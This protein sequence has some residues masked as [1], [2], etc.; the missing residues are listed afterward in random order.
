MQTVVFYVFDVVCL[1]VCNIEIRGKNQRYLRVSDRSLA[2]MSK[3]RRRSEASEVETDEYPA[4][5]R[6]TGDKWT[7]PPAL[8]RQ[9]P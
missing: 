7:V 2:D 6:K 8:N 1:S 4:K 3:R 9:V 5:K